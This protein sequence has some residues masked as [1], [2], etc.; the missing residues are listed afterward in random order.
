MYGNAATVPSPRIGFF[1]LA[2]LIVLC[3]GCA[4]ASRT[5]SFV[6]PTTQPPA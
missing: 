3:P 5:T 6:N 1:L 4:D 2:V